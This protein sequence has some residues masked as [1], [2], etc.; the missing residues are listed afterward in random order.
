MNEYCP[1]FVLNGFSTKC[2]LVLDMFLTKLLIKNGLLFLQRLNK[3]VQKWKNI[4]YF[5]GKILN[6]DRKTNSSFPVKE[7]IFT[8]IKRK[9][10]FAKH[11]S[12]RLKIDLFVKWI[13]ATPQYSKRFITKSLKS[14]GLILSVKRYELLASNPV[15]EFTFLQIDTICFSKLSLLSII[16]PRSLNVFTNLIFLISLQI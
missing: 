14:V 11:F 8:F 7:K 6:L 4:L 13:R 3:N 16:N 5:K 2:L 10:D 15:I 1:Y 12:K 9:I